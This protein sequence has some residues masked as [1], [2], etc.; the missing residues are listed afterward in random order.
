MSKFRTLDADG[1][2]EE[3]H[4]NWKERIA[5]PYRNMAPQPR[6]ATDSHLRLVL[7]DKPWPIPSGSGVGIGGPYNRP[8]PRRDGMKN[9]NSRLADMDSER[10][11]LAVLFGG[12]IAGTIS[13]LWKM[14]A[15]PS[16]WRAP[17][18]IGWRSTAPRIVRA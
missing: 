18:M 1:H 11:D 9:P 8:H 12:G 16:L 7:E 14:P 6:P 4:V 2:V 10:I 5:E 15:S 3:A 17:V 13:R